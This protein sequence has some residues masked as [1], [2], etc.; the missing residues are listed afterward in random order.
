M[1][2]MLIGNLFINIG[3]KVWVYIYIYIMYIT[4]SISSL[5]TRQTLGS[6]QPPVESV[7]R[8][9]A[10]LVLLSRC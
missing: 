8:D 3:E 2:L 10:D 4:L 6:D 5:L 1:T 7:C 9:P